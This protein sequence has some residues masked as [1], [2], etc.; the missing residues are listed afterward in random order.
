[1]VDTAIECALVVRVGFHLSLRTTEGFLES[2][3][4]LMSHTVNRDPQRSPTPS[5]CL[6]RLA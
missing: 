1:M 4:E 3:V 6:L 2:L 5:G